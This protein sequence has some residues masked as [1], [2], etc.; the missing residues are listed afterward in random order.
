EAYQQARALY[1]RL[2]VPF[3]LAWVHYRLG[4][5]YEA[6]GQLMEAQRE[7]EE[8][9]RIVESLRQRAAT[10]Q[11][12]TG[13]VEQFRDVYAAWVRVLLALDRRPEAFHAAE[14]AHGRTL[15]DILTAGRAD[16]SKGLSPEER[17]R[18]Q[19]L[20]RKVA[21]LN[22]RLAQEVG[23]AE[24]DEV[25]V[26]R[27]RLDLA[28]AR[29]ALEEYQRS[30]YARH[31]DLAARR[32]AQP[33]K[34]PDLATFLPPD[35]GLL[36]YLMGPQRTYLFAVTAEGAQVNLQV[37]TI[38]QPRLMLTKEVA[39]LRRTYARRRPNYAAAQRLYEW[40]LKP[41]LTAWADREPRLRRLVIVPDGA[42]FELPFQALVRSD[43]EGEPFLWEDFELVYA[44]SASILKAC[45][46]EARAARRRPRGMLLIFA[47]PDF[48]PRSW[49]P[50]LTRAG[51]LAPLP[52][53][54]A[55][56][57]AIAAE[58][59]ETAVVYQ[60]AAAQ[61]STAKRELPH[62]RYLHFATHGFLDAINP[63]YSA[64]A[65]AAPPPDSEED[66]FLEA[67]ELAQLDLAAELVVLSA[68]ETARGR[69]RQG[70]GL[71]GLTWAVFAAG[72]PSAVVSQWAVSDRSTQ[73]LMAA[74]YR[75]LKAGRGKA[76]ALRQAALELLEEYEQPFYWAPFILVGEWE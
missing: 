48:G 62:Y 1:W 44:V 35:T 11:A 55:E 52:G 19:K 28:E 75:Y 38:E 17:A 40:L 32:G 59:G 6:R 14:R 51:A 54:A 68:C 49:Q 37:Y 13:T 61:E 15:L 65:L 45:R 43:R 71:L 53:T 33:I 58:Y 34:G 10:E 9:V 25:L 50:A 66:G 36:E 31:P 69:L 70:E 29:Q 16:L 7:L 63:L 4:C 20:D 72:A 24:P 73:E 21:A 8:A 57:A 47:N 30:L 76:A 22:A 64:I 2:N 12:R 3:S 41:A 56:A 46:E 27:L 67:R 18:E 74:F 39:A 42:L 60:G 5:V 23:R 26:K